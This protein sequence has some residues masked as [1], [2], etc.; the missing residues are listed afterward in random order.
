MAV[1]GKKVIRRWFVCVS[2]VVVRNVVE[3]FLYNNISLEDNGDAEVFSR[4]NF[5]SFQLNQTSRSPPIYVKVRSS[6]L[7]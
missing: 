5:A 3:V 6:C 1:V 7:L 4:P 2:V